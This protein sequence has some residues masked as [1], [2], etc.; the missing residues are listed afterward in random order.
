MLH[1][2]LRDRA[3]QVLVPALVGAL[4]LGLGAAVVGMPMS[5]AG[6]QMAT[7]TR[8]VDARAAA[9]P[10]AAQTT[11]GSAELS[12][13]AALPADPTAALA[14]AGWQINEMTARHP[15]P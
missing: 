9:T 14:L 2:L 15:E 10:I 12:P 3:R 7:A 11:P 13:L 6:G 8:P 4:T 1:E 5:Q